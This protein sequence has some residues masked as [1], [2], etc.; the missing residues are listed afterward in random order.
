MTWDINAVSLTQL[1]DISLENAKTLYKDCKSQMRRL[2]NEM[3]S[4]VDDMKHVGALEDRLT[5]KFDIEKLIDT[6]D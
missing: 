4:I 1:N 3:E 6:E 2:T 5:S